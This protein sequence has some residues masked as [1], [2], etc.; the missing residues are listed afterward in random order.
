MCVCVCVCE[1]E[2]EREH[3]CAC[4]HACVCVY[5][6]MRACLY[7]EGGW[8]LMTNLYKII[9]CVSMSVVFNL[10][11]K[12]MHLGLIGERVLKDPTAIIIISGWSSTTL[13]LMIDWSALASSLACVITWASLWVRN[14]SALC[15]A[16]KKSFCVDQCN[17]M[18]L[19]LLE[20]PAPISP[21]GGGALALSHTCRKPSLVPHHLT[22]FFFFFFFFLC[23]PVC[24]ELGCTQFSQ[25]LG[26]YL[27]PVSLSLCLSPHP[28]S[29]HAC[30]S[31]SL[32]LSPSP[33]H[34]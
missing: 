26:A 33:P 15:W 27:Q 9:L 17:L 6:C 14:W 31:L 30:L 21:Q 34:T 20:V 12:S 2:R 13:G 19:L 1:R 23:Q 10:S 16:G 3:V 24:C 11:M 18:G 22:F 28:P 25:S 7:R 4:L 8:C 32:P 29:P 5:V